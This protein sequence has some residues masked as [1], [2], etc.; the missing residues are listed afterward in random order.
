[1]LMVYT[2]YSLDKRCIN[3]WTSNIY[4]IAYMGVQC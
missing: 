2:A 1:M 3:E 4:N